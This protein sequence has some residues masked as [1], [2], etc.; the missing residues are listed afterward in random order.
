VQSRKKLLLSAKPSPIHIGSS[1]LL[2]PF[3]A[4]LLT[5]QPA[6]FGNENDTAAQ[7]EQNK[8]NDNAQ[9]KWYRRYAVIRGSQGVKNAKKQQHENT[10]SLERELCVVN[11][12]EK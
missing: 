4:F 10:K 6:D 12:N 5:K 9:N 2:S 8:H 11:A 7:L 3:F 1:Q